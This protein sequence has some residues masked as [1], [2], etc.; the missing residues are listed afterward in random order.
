[1]KGKGKKT[2]SHILSPTHYSSC[3]RLPPFLHQWEIVFF[4]FFFL[5]L[6]I[7]SSLANTKGHK[8]QSV[9]PIPHELMMG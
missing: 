3:L 2:I 8:A 4:F 7:C 5:R 1:M 6:A 9:R